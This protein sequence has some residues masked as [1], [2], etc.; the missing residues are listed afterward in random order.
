MHPAELRV[1]RESMGLSAEWLGERFHESAE[2]ITAW[3][4]GET[5]IPED[6]IEEMHELDYFV[7]SMADE[8]VRDLRAAGAKQ[9]IYSVPRTD[10]DS[11]NELPASL[12]RA[13]GARVRILLPDTELDYLE[14]AES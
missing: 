9:S 13:I 14:P 1:L 4:S 10:E 7:E 6:I 3:E 5:P 2:T 11:P 8:I 12:W